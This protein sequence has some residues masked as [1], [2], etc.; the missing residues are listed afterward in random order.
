MLRRFREAGPVRIS[1]IAGLADTSG[2]S[3]L[4]IWCMIFTPGRPG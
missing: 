1:E 3:A 2:G 4:R